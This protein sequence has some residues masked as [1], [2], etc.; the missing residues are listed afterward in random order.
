MAGMETSAKTMK[1]HWPPVVV[2]AIEPYL[3]HAS[4]QPSIPLKNQS[5]QYSSII[6]ETP[7]ISECFLGSVVWRRRGAWLAERRRSDHGRG[8]SHPMV[9]MTEKVK[10]SVL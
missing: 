6:W 8:V 10:S 7:V 3:P 5:Q 1:K 2:G 4:N 9:V